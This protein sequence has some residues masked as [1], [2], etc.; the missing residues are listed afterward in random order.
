MAK[1]TQIL[2]LVDKA[3]KYSV[4]YH[5]GDKMNP[6]WV[7]RHTWELRE[8]GYGYGERKRIVVKYADIKSCLYYLASVM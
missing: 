5:E 4:V 6:F 7:Y 2:K 8:C 1:T 3:G